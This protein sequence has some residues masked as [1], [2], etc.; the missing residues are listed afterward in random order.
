MHR[1]LTF[2][3]LPGSSSP[4]I[5][6]C[7]AAA[8][9]DAREAGVHACALVS[10]TPPPRHFVALRSPGA[11][12]A[13]SPPRSLFR[14]VRFLGEAYACLRRFPAAALVQ[15]CVWADLWNHLALKMAIVNILQL[16]RGCSLLRDVAV[17]PGYVMSARWF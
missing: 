3:L 11:L 4:T 17:T 8:S 6:T 7:A 15:P 5:W 12:S 9:A 16:A 2:R 14:V 1:L 10:I 13:P